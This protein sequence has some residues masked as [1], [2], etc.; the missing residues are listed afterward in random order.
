MENKQEKGRSISFT[1]EI[2]MQQEAEDELKREFQASQK[3]NKEDSFNL[4]LFK[5]IFKKVTR[6]AYGNILN[7]NI[8]ARSAMEHKGAQ[9]LGI[10]NQDLSRSDKDK[11]TVFHRAALEQN[12]VLLRDLCKKASQLENYT[13][14]YI[15]KRDKFGNSPLICACILNVDGPEDKRYDCLKVLLETSADPNVQNYRTQWT[16]LTWC[17][18]YGDVN[19][20]ELL[21][22]KGAH[23]YYPDHEGYY[24]IDWAGTQVDMRYFLN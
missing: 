11:R 13:N 19:S 15:D 18:Y 23:P 12:I 3:K 6:K 9:A 8:I 16:A 7:E 1:N 2:L 4:N 20:I 22:E 24:P 10:Q 21:L 14:L 17:S 5:S